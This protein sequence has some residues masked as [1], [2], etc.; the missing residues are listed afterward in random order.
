[1]II[2][3]SFIIPQ[4][5]APVLIFFVALEINLHELDLVRPL[6]IRIYEPQSGIRSTPLQRPAGKFLDL[7]YRR[8]TKR[9]AADLKYTPV[10]QPKLMEEDKLCLDERRQIIFERPKPLDQAFQV[11]LELGQTRDLT[12]RRR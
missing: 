12:E 4:Y 7:V 11:A 5:S 8:I 9:Q 6:K 1:M 10:V 3:N 2:F